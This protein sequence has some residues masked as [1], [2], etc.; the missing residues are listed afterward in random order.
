MYNKLY[1]PVAPRIVDNKLYIPV[2]SRV[3]HNKL[4]IPVASRVI[5]NKLYI[6]VASR[7]VHN[8]LY[9]P[10]ASRVIIINFIYRLQHKL[11]KD[12]N[13]EKLRKSSNWVETK[14]SA[15]SFFQK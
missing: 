11:S 3:V 4:Y 2:A 14:T 5:H 15:K 1:I 8:K 6:P 9:I 13:S 12:G 10:V 7:V